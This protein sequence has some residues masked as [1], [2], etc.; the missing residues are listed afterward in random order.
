[1]SL[2]II[3]SFLFFFDISWELTKVIIS[4]AYLSFLLATPLF[5]TSLPIYSK[6]KETTAIKT[7]VF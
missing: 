1:M 2:C 6:K 3:F 7:V 5:F 4:V